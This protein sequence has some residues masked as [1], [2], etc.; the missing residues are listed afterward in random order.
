MVEIAKGTF[1]VKLQALPFEGVEAGAKLG[2][3][4]IDKEIEGDLIATTR[5]QMLS[6]MTATE[7]SAGYVA[8]EH[9]EGSLKGKKGSFVLQHTGVM[10][11]GSPGLS[12]I[13]VPDSG[14]GELAGLTGRFDINIEAGSHR[15]E[16]EYT[17]PS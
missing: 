13:V 2:R 12:V 1:K 9:V 4:S 15:Y 16:F 11:R 14:S 10:D 5:G 3:M 17:L 8:I 6:A 7:G